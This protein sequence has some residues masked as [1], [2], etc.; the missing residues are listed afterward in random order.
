MEKLLDQDQINAMFR[1]QRAPAQDKPEVEGPQPVITICDLRQTTPLTTDHVRTITSL[2]ESVCR[3]LT[4]SLGAY[5]R[6]GFE[7]EVVSVEQLNYAEFLGRLPDIT[8]LC[9]LGIAPLSATAVLQMDLQLGFAV[10]DLLLGGQGRPGEES[11]EATEIEE[12]VLGGIVKIVARELANGWSPAG[13]EITFEERQL[14]AAAQRLMRPA[15]KVVVVSFEFRIPQVRG[16]VNIG[17]PAVA[18]NT[19]LRKMLREATP[20][21]LQAHSE[22]LLRELLLDCKFT[23]RLQLPPSQLTV[24]EL[25][26]MNPGTVLPLGHP[27]EKQIVLTVEDLDVF[28]A[29]PVRTARRRGAQLV[30]G[31]KRLLEAEVGNG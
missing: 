27:V 24:R 6:I 12:E 22:A 30:D 5:L 31:S 17:F 7:A 25:A 15:E 23:C 20:R 9:S 10:I 18:A 19:L 1:N 2:H 8:Y 3:N 11:R 21:K 26:K 13:F 28:P 29:R 4:H 16:L 14:A